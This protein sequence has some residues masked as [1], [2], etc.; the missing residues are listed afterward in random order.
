VLSFSLSRPA[1]VHTALV[2]LDKGRKV[3]TRCATP[4]A[5]NRTRRSCVRAVKI[6]AKALTGVAGKNA[7]TLAALA[8]G[9]KLAAGSYRI[10]LTLSG[11]PSVTMNVTIRT[12]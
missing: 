4:T 7:V 12:R 11:V 2:R 6:G 8:G 10:T 5:K 1:P 9:K 3:G